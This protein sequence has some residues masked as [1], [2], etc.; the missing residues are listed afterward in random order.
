MGNVTE[1]GELVISKISDYFLKPEI[2]GNVFQEIDLN[3]PQLSLGEDFR[4][5]I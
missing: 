3:P 4:K 1:M 2:G 5:I